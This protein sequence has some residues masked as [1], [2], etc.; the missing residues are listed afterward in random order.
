MRLKNKT[1]PT[2]TRREVTIFN[3]R[4]RNILAASRLTARLCCIPSR[5]QPGFPSWLTRTTPLAYPL[6][7]AGQLIV[8][9]VI[10]R[11]ATWADQYARHIP[12][13][14]PIRVNR[15][16]F[17]PATCP[18]PVDAGLANGNWFRGRSLSTQPL[19]LY[20]FARGTAI[21]WRKST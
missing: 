14:V 16:V 17:L 3:P 2:T 1:S 9:R 19:S 20:G 18:P 10:T 12:R 4:R 8:L 15:H 21:L 11:K 7:D 5:V 6:A 13:P